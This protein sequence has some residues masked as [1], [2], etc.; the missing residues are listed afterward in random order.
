MSRAERCKMLA[1]RVQNVNQQPVPEFKETV[2]ELTT[3]KVTLQQE[4]DLIK[5]FE[6]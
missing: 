6:S 2:N 3:S 1:A 5:P 4:S